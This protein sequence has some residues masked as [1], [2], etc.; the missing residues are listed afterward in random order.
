MSY[1]QIRGWMDFEDVYDIA[2]AE[3]RDGDTLIEV[4]VAYG[5][6]LA[7]LTRAAMTSGKDLHII[8]VDP[9]DSVWGYWDDLSILVDKAGGAR[10]AF[11][12]EMAKFA[13]EERQR[14]DVWQATSLAAASRIADHPRTVSFVFIDAVHDYEHC[15]EDIAAWMP[16]IRPGGIIA[17]HDH[18]PSWPGVEQAVR[19]AFGDGYE[20][21]GSSWI[22]RLP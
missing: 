10:E 8:G 22:K 12:G 13:P 5:K 11:E 20:V 6:G 14:A 16:L 1:D 21:R 7:Y 15:K 2:I 19:E 3:A 17:G 18:T 4:G 9:W